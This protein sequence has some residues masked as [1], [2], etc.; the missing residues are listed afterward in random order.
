MAVGEK[1][2]L[3]TMIFLIPGCCAA[4]RVEGFE[5]KYTYS[6]RANGIDIA[7]YGN[8]KGGNAIIYAAQ[9]TGEVPAEETAR[10]PRRNRRQLLDT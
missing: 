4:G 7:R 2:G 6:R 10:K 3:Q 8:Q 5:D 1:T 9:V